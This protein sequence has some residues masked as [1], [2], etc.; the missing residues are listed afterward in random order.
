VLHHE[1]PVY[2][3][4]FDLLSV[5]V[6]LT[7]NLPR[8]LKR[9]LGDEVLGGCTQMVVLV[10]RANIAREKVP[11]IEELLERVEVVNLLL[12]VLVEKHFISREQYA[13]A[14]QLTTSIGKQ[15]GGWKKASAA[16]PAPRSP[17]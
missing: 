14:I 17:R 5:A 16:S 6:D 9:H 3:T 4:T 1:L 15:A 2:K 13:R 12:R 10:F 8:D 11:H 7:R